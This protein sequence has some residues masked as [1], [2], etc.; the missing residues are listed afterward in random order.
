MIGS[1]GT[2]SPPHYRYSVRSTITSRHFTTTTT[3]TSPLHHKNPPQLQLAKVF[4]SGWTARFYYS[5]EVPPLVLDELRSLGAELIPMGVHEGIDG[6]FWR[7]Q[8][9]TYLP[10]LGCRNES[11][12]QTSNHAVLPA[13][14]CRAGG[15][16]PRSGPISSSRHRLAPQR[17]RA[18]RR[19]GVGA[20]RYGP[21]H[22]E[23]PSE[24]RAKPDHGLLLGRTARELG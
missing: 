3:T 18:L 4:Y 7:F 5:S 17:S 14:L 20:E 16:R 15:E 6:M 23:R 11:T 21:S 19:R 9:P 22:D 2:T 1:R 13:Y 10:T 24:A 12:P 8:V